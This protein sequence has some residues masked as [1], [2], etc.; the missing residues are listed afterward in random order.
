MYTLQ[1]VQ[2]SDQ[3]NNGKNITKRKEKKEKNAYYFLDW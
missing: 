2:E 1:F 3:K